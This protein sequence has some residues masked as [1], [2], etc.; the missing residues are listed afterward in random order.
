SSVNPGA[1][2]ETYGREENCRGTKEH[3]PVNPC[4][5]GM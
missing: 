4:P 3:V 2:R 1:K 5:C